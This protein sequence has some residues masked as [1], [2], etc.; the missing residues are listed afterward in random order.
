MLAREALIL[1]AS[2]GLS[3]WY[4]AGLDSLGIH[5]WQLLLV[6]QSVGQ[7]LLPRQLGGYQFHRTATLWLAG[8]SRCEVLQAAT[9]L[10]SQTHL[11]KLLLCHL[12]QLSLI[13]NLA[14]SEFEC[15]LI[16]Q[17]SGSIMNGI[18]RVVGW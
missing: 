12:H 10:L 15:L 4:R 16:L 7:D 18:V 17:V 2:L 5:Q 13:L 8:A 6:S 14:L 1:R 3:S 11:I 9:W